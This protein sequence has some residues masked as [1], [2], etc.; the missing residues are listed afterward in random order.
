MKQA[1]AF[2][3]IS[4]PVVAWAAYRG[5]LVSA[6]AELQPPKCPVSMMF[7]SIL[8]HNNNTRLWNE[9]LIEKSR[10]R[11]F[12]HCQSRLT[13]M[14]FFEEQNI[15]ELACEWG[16]HF[17]KNNLVEL[18]LYPTSKTFRHDANWITYAP[19]DQRG[20]IISEKWIPQY[21]SGEKYPGKSPVWELIVQ[22]RGVIYGIEVRERAYQNFVKEFPE[23]VSILE[24]ARIAACVGSD[25][26]QSNAWL[27]RESENSIRLSYFL[28]MRDA[29]NPD[30]LERIR[31]YDG[32]RNYKDLA[33][34]GDKFRLPDFGKLSCCFSVK[35]VLYDQFL[36][37]IHRN[38]KII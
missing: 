2:L 38:A 13:G 29:H 9:L 15:A 27:I 36:F 17:E 30:L 25:L 18:G 19:V 11:H 34:G 5:V 12:P 33:V 1:F 28:D 32:P 14:Y 4:N 24:V 7:A 6:N 8:L 21:W 31:L 10:Q 37:S 3:D 35:D 23:A 22:G 20:K 26:G 16:G